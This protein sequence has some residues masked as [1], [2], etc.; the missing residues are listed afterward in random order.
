MRAGI[1][2]SLQ[3]A[4]LLTGCG[5]TAYQHLQD[6]SPDGCVSAF[7]KPLSAD[8]EA[9]VTPYAEL[10]R[11][12]AAAR[13]RDVELSW[14][15]RLERFHWSE[16]RYEEPEGSRLL[17]ETGPTHALG[18]SAL[19]ADRSVRLGAEF[20]IGEVD[21]DGQ[22]WGGTPLTTETEYRG[23]ELAY[24]HQWD[25][26]SR[27]WD[28]LYLSCGGSMRWWSRDLKS[29]SMATGY[30]EQWFVMTVDFGIVV[31]HTMRAEDRFFFEAFTHLPL[32]TAEHISAFSADIEP[33]G[34]FRLPA[35]LKVG[36]GWVNGLA[37][38]F[39]LRRMGFDRSASTDS[40]VG[41]VLQPASTMTRVGLE[42]EY[43]F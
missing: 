7:P 5:S 21:Y 39:R 9:A 28:N 17:E 36:Y 22:T 42:V 18:F 43:R 34:K 6:A 27:F 37:L 23:I 41:P 38:S 1:L 4:L 2:L 30:V 31:G 15:W 40:S 11:A 3:L 13:Y 14:Y 25:L 35:E 26:Y 20:M 10:T 8:D 16:Y 12:Q 24:T 19:L 33:D 29:T 32:A